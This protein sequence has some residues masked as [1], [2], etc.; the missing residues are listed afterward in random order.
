MSQRGDIT[1]AHLITAEYHMGE[2]PTNPV[3]N[4]RYKTAT[5]KTWA[6][7]VHPITN[8]LVVHTYAEADGRTNAIFEPYMEPMYED[9]PHRGR[10]YATAPNYRKWRF[11]YEADIE[12]WFHTEVSNVVLSAWARYPSILQ[13]SHNKPLSAEPISQNVDAT[14]S[15]RIN[16]ARVPVIIGEFKRNIIKTTVWQSGN[17]KGE[18]QKALSREL[19]G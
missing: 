16:G 7:D 11:E 9:D 1:M 6:D 15:A 17:V 4:T 8:Q 12:N 13:T 3:K 5:G 2:H 14:Y 10:E 18:G 19:R